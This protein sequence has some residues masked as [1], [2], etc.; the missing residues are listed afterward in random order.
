MPGAYRGCG[1][2]GSMG[3][4]DPPFEKIALFEKKIK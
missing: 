4:V 3:A 1:G 2:G